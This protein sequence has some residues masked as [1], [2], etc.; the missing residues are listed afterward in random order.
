M[1]KWRAGIGIRGYSLFQPRWNTR[2]VGRVLNRLVETSAYSRQCAVAAV[3][4]FT[5]AM[6]LGVWKPA[7]ERI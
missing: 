2:C 1:S 5:A 7:L 6:P 4:W 3:A